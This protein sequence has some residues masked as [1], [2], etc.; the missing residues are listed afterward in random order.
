MG[1]EGGDIVDA[2]FYLFD[3]K[4]QGLQQ[5]AQYPDN[6]N[7]TLFGIEGKC[8]AN[9]FGPSQRKGNFSLYQVD[10]AEGNDEINYVLF[11]TPILASINSDLLDFYKNGTYPN[12]T[13]DG[14]DMFVLL[15]GYNDKD[16]YLARNF[17]GQ[18]WGLNGDFYT[19]YYDF[20]FY[21]YLYD[22]LE[23]SGD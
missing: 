12:D 15:Y 23:V 17:W 7:T 5:K 18:D 22:N 2:F 16:G 21:L 4:H 20:G 6:I 3:F 19:D 1:C 10:I 8:K 9:L 14:G 11:N 13:Y